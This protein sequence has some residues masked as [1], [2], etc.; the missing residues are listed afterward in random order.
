MRLSNPMK[1][2]LDK[3]YQAARRSY[4]FRRLFFSLP[5]NIRLKLIRIFAYIKTGVELRSSGFQDSR[6][7][8]MIDW[9]SFFTN[10]VFI[11]SINPVDFATK[12]LKKFRLS[13]NDLPGFENSR[14]P[15]KE[16]L[17]SQTQLITVDFW[18]TLVYR[19][20]PS[21][22]S[23]I[24][25]SL[26]ISF[27]EWKTTNF[28]ASRR[29]TEEIYENRL[30]LESHDFLENGETSIY[31][32]YE[33]LL[34]QSPLYSIRQELI[35]LEKQDEVKFSSVN[36]DLE[37]MLISRKNSAKFVVSDFYMSSDDIKDI[38]SKLGGQVPFT[39][40]FSSS[41]SGLT[42]RIQGKLF[43]KL[44]RS[45]ND[46]WLHI[47]DNIH[48]D[49]AMSE[50]QGAK[51]LHID[52]FSHRFNDEKPV[53]N[54]SNLMESL[55][56]SPVHGV[57]K[58][59]I[60]VAI[61]SYVLISSAIELALKSNKGQ[62]VYLSREGATLNKIHN[63][64]SK[65]IK[66]Q[67]G[68]EINSKYLPIS[69]ASSLMCSFADSPEFGLYY[70]SDQYPQM[71]SDSFIQTLS[72]HGKLAEFLRESL[73]DYQLYETR[74]IWSKINSGLR[75]DITAHL[76]E[77]RKLLKIL[78][79]EL[80]I[81]PNTSLLCD[82]GWRGTIQDSLSLIYM[83]PFQGI[84]LGT[85]TPF[86]SQ[87]SHPYCGEKLGV[88]WDQEL[89]IDPPSEFTFPGPLERAFTLDPSQVLGY[90][91]VNTRNVSL[92]KSRAES[93][94]TFINRVRYFEREFPSIFKCV[95]ESIFSFGSFGKESSNIGIGALQEWFSNPSR[96]QADLWF[97]ENHSEGFGVGDKVHYSKHFPDQDWLGR[98]LKE[99]LVSSAVAAHWAHGYLKT[100]P[101]NSLLELNRKPDE[102]S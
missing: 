41:D 13:D 27:L 99:S 8:S 64:L 98:N 59:L 40:F 82:L 95:S 76:Q 63:L 7:D 85:N 57:D 21:E 1:Q 26:R 46:E 19:K 96:Q 66:T 79:S 61:L 67:L 32:V 45:Q 91:L 78:C 73:G 56:S 54:Y 10:I 4:R 84:Y 6:F 62:I 93:N 31:R 3:V 90:K 11:P 14:I 25:S 83:N 9:N 47:G 69:R 86:D 94:E 29:S 48:S 17:T 39:T 35:E 87:R 34:K 97:L 60:E 2:L 49:V 89:G 88:L 28:S 77:Q 43:E 68:V 92:R 20:R 80:E 15:H 30:A 52:A 16:W 81:D 58:Y 65:L 12:S 51:S 42:K 5:L 74:K 72:L 23:K 33:Q 53:G 75:K 22:S 100:T 36:Y 38:Y 50:K 70:I 37:L 102:S 101:I 71:S 44:T 24:L 55:K 18:D